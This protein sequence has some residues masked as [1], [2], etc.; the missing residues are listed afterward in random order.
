MDNNQNT[1]MSKIARELCAVDISALS[2]LFKI[3]ENRRT[4]VPTSAVCEAVSVMCYDAEHDD[5][6]KAARIES[7]R[8][9]LGFLADNDYI[10][11]DSE[12]GMELAVIRAKGRT[13]FRS[14]RRQ[15]DAWQAVY[16]V[17]R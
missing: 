4:A 1:P 11:I 5:E 14:L 3:G 2:Y 9:R 17:T 16:L 7:I 6:K 13:R 10:E 15:A 8:D 12:I